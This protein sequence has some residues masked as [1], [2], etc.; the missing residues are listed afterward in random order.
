MKKSSTTIPFI[1]EPKINTK[2]LKNGVEL[3]FIDVP[4]AQATDVRIFFDTGFK[5]FNPETYH[6]PHVFEHII[7]ESRIDGK[8]LQDRVMAYG[9]ETNASTQFDLLTMVMRVPATFAATGVKEMVNTIQGVKVTEALVE[10]EK[11]VVVREAADQFDGLASQ[12]TAYMYS[13]VLSDHVPESYEAT[14][15]SIEEITTDSVKKFHKKLFT[16]CGLRVMVTGDLSATM[17]TDIATTLETISKRKAYGSL[18]HIELEADC[19]SEAMPVAETSALTVFNLVTQLENSKAVKL[20]NSAELYV[21]ARYFSNPQNDGLKHLR[22]MGLLYGIDVQPSRYADLG[23]RTYMLTTDAAR[24]REGLLALLGILFGTLKTVDDEQFRLVKDYMKNSMPLTHETVEEV[25]E[26]YTTDLTASRPFFHVSEGAK[27]FAE[28]T[29]EQVRVQMHRVLTQSKWQVGLAADAPDEA[30]FV[31]L[32]QLHEACQKTKTPDECY[33]VYQDWKLEAD[34]LPA[35]KLSDNLDLRRLM[36]TFAAFVAG[37]LAFVPYLVLDNSQKLSSLYDL[38]VQ[39]WL[40]GGALLYCILTLLYL[41]DGS[42]KGSWKPALVFSGAASGLIGFAYTIF[43]LDK[44]ADNSPV[45]F[46]G[47][48]AGTYHFIFFVILC[49]W[50]SIV[51]IRAM[52]DSR[53]NRS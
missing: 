3:T 6:V 23:D 50:I 20:A 8:S 39:N 51:M 28:L 48:I 40:V 17:K 31:A 33:D 42:F 9:A 53:M 36:I 24:S 26:W 47:D 5:D 22:D 11:I 41:P 18:K 21:Y 14:I 30:F 38:L 12:V 45:S 1:R 32:Q 27:L 15:L 25:A 4:G 37:G 13:K 49:G 35:P 2:S 19:S 46:W 44:T 43:A 7:M 52:L 10:R 16:T 29:P 34:K